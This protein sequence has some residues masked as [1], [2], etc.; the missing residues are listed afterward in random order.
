MR[1][2][3][4]P[5]QPESPKSSV[6]GPPLQSAPPPPLAPLPRARR[7]GLVAE[8]VAYL[9]ENKKWWL[10]PIVVMVVV[11]GLLF[12]LVALNP[13]LAPFIYTLF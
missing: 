12:V 6:A 4:Q 9:R 13:A 7:T 10:I 2:D 5:Q 11:F 8:F 1:S 3:P